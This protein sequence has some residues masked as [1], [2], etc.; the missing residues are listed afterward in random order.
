[1]YVTHL[2]NTVSKQLLLEPLLLALLWFSSVNQPEIHIETISVESTINVQETK[3]IAYAKETASLQ[4]GRGQFQYF[5]KIISKESMGWTV[6]TAHYPTGYTTTGVK[7]SAYGLGGFLD[8]TWEGVGC[9]KTDN[10][11]TQ[12]ECTAQY[13]TD[14]YGTPELAWEFHRKNN[15]Y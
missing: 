13:I 9:V 10:P 14:R 3:L 5:D 7:S 4:W 11:Y 1:M 12:V 15:W 6:T 8:A 2:K